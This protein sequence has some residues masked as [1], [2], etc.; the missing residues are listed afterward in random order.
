MTTGDLNSISIVHCV[1]LCVHGI[2]IPTNYILKV[3]MIQL[4]YT[5]VW[6]KPLRNYSGDRIATVFMI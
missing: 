5:I 2:E 4:N 6:L 3:S 1:N